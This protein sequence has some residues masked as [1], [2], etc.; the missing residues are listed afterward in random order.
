MSRID[1]SG[2]Q[3]SPYWAGFVFLDLLVKVLL[4]IIY[5]DSAINPRVRPLAVEPFN[6]ET[7]AIGR[8]WP[9]QAHT[10]VGRARL[11]NL[12]KLSQQVLE[13]GIAGDFIETGVWRGGCCIL[14]ARGSRPRTRFA[15]ARS[16]LPTRL[17]AS[18]RQMK[19]STRPTL[20]G[21]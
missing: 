11:E 7:R 9:T 5:E 16:M 14:D 8:D 15:T 3:R 19:S 17:Q 6:P 2:K 10:M 13:D 20:D 12:R 21:I 1:A 18:R 4:N